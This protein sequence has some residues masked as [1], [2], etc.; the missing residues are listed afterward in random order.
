MNLTV[1]KFLCP[2]LAV[3]LLFSGCERKPRTGFIIKTWQST[4]ANRKV[5]GIDDGSAYFGGY[6][7]GFSI[8]IWTDIMACGFPIKAAW[9]K[10]SNCAKY[11]GHLKS[12]SGQKIDVECYVADRMKGLM[13]INQQEYDLANGSLFLISFRSPQI[14]VVQINQDIYAMTTKG[15]AWKQLLENAPEIKAFYEVTAAK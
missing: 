10:T 3:I 13:T 4:S 8:I 5:H 9:D 15:K 11:S 12:A 14:R 1:T 6:R 2:V 7:E